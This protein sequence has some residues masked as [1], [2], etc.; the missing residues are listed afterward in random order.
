MRVSLPYPR[1]PLDRAIRTCL[2]A[3]P[4][5]VS[6]LRIFCAEPVSGRLV[7]AGNERPAPEDIDLPK[8]F[9]YSFEDDLARIPG[10]E[11][12]ANGSG[13]GP[14]RTPASRPKAIPGRMPR[15][16]QGRVE[17]V[18]IWQETSDC[19][20]NIAKKHYGNPFLWP[21]IYEANR[22]AIRDPNVIFP[23]QKLLIPPAG[24]ESGPRGR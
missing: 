2:L 14:S 19:L 15:A 17:T 24:P 18:W 10:V 6:G 11:A 22:A 13:A 16:Q 21:K 1:V 4:L 8:L 9:S 7:G 23:K 12:V 3:G 20:W 5:L